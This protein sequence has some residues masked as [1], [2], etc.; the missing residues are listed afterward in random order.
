MNAIAASL[1]RFVSRTP[2]PSADEIGRFLKELLLQYSWGGFYRRYF[3]PAQRDRLEKV[4]A[5][6]VSLESICLTFHGDSDERRL[7]FELQRIKEQTDIDWVGLP[8]E[9]AHFLGVPPLFFRKGPRKPGLELFGRPGLEGSNIGTASL[10]GPAAPELVGPLDQSVLGTQLNQH[11]FDIQAAAETGNV[12]VARQA[13]GAAFELVQE[14][15]AYFRSRPQPAASVLGDA[16]G[17]LAILGDVEHALPMFRLALSFEGTPRVT[18][19]NLQRLAGM[20]IGRE[21]TTLYPEAE[22]AIKRLSEPPLDAISPERTQLLAAGL[23]MARGE[24]RGSSPTAWIDEL[25]EQFEQNPTEPMKFYAVMA[26][27]T[28]TKRYDEMRRLARLRYETI[29][30]A[31]DAYVTLR[32]LADG[33][34][35]SDNEADEFEAMELYKFI[36]ERVIPVS[37]KARDARVE[38]SFNYGTL[39]YVKDY[40]DEAGRLFFEAYKAEPQ[41]NKIQAAYSNYLARARRPDLAAKVSRGEM[42]TEMILQP[43]EK[44]IPE[45][46]LPKETPRWW[47]RSPLLKERKEL[48]AGT[49]R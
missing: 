29:D 42:I 39:L 12:A 37:A 1:R 25:V 40:D 49:E 36:L 15:E 17:A 3:L 38:V 43:A 11:L 2:A 18:V 5:A 13:A 47:E 34:G 46:F 9:L 33:L 21:L 6:L 24:V 22:A 20:I 7:R 26:M 30:T 14:Q 28:G 35:P 44:R 45:S 8:L 10:A 31:D 19:N 48:A 4:H 32:V 41:H 23:L 27:A 16:A